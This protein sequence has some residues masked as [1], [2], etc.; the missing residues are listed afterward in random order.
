MRSFAETPYAEL[1]RDP[2]AFTAGIAAGTAGVAAGVVSGTTRWFSQLSG[3]VGTVA[4]ALSFDEQFIHQRRLLMR[5]EA[6]TTW[7]GA[8]QG[9]TALNAGLTGGLTGL[10]TQPIGASQEGWRRAGAAGGALGLAKG[11]AQ[12][13]VAWRMCMCCA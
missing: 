2:L 9:F 8:K 11:A 7:Q 13:T 1:T 3:G 10:V 4:G 12:A 5:R 6:T